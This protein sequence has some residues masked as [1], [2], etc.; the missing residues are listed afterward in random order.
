MK[1][2]KVVKQVISTIKHPCLDG[3]KLYLVQPVLPDGTNTGEAFVTIDS[4][5]SSI[6]NTVLI[7]QEGGGTQ[8]VLNLKGSPVQSVIVG[9][10][11]KI[12]KDER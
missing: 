5:Q 10:V 7:D 9:I 4:V 2:A 3:Q 6:G 11:D 1:L 8:Q 12:T